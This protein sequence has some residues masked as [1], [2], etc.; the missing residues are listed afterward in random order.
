MYYCDITHVY[1][2]VKIYGEYISRDVSS[3]ALC[4]IVLII[5]SC[6]KCW[7]LQICYNGTDMP[8]PFNMEILKWANETRKLLCSAKLPDQIKFYNIYGTNNDTPH[9]VWYLKLF[10]YY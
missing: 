4:F 8:V 3:G 10:E 6:I 9:C 7:L 2:G 5:I 1:F